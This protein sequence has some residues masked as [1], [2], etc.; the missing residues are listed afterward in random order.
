MPSTTTAATAQKS[1]SWFVTTRWSV[2][3]TA[4]QHDTTQSRDA[5]TQLCNDYWYPLYA[6]VRRRGH[7]PHDAQDLTHAFFECL[8]ERQSLA[9]ADPSKGGFRSFILGAM[10]Y[11]LATEWARLQTQKR[12]G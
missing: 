7:S 4:G 9:T 5:L 3:M 8:L 11:F 10:N 2:V 1:N 6:Y 12:G